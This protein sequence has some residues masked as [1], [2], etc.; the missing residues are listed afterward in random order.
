MV[1]PKQ[2]KHKYIYKNKN[3]QTLAK[4]G[5][6]KKFEGVQNELNFT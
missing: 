2:E 1:K 5:I 3:K 4:S 6:K